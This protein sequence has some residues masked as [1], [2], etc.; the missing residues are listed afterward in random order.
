MIRHQCSKIIS[1]N[2]VGKFAL[3]AV[4]VLGGAI[5]MANV[6]DL[7]VASITNKMNVLFS[8]T[9]GIEAA[10]KVEDKFTFGYEDEY[11]SDLA[12]PN[13]LVQS[14]EFFDQFNDDKK[15][16]CIIISDGRMNKE[17]VRTPLADAEQKEYMYFYIVLDKQKSEESII[18]YKTTQI[19]KVD[20]KMSVQI[21]PYLTDFPFRFYIIVNVY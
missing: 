2:N 4:T 20:G 7:H 10:M 13:F 1:E 8:Q 12:I 6:G 17:L 18:N 5:S 19:D 9:A 21:K 3:E 11:S 15:N 14:R 16:I